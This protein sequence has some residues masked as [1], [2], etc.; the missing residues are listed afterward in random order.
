MKKTIDR[1]LIKT[2]LWVSF[3]IALLCIFFGWLN[4][5]VNY[6]R[7][8]IVFFSA[9]SA[10]NFICFQNSW[11]EKI[12]KKSSF[13]LVTVSLLLVAYF[14][15]KEK[16][17]A[18]LL[19]ILFVGSIVIMYNSNF[20]KIRFRNLPLLKI[21]IISFAWVYTI[22]LIGNTNNSR[23]ISEFLSLY[24]FIFGITIPFDICDM[25]ED[26]IC[27]IPKYLGIRK[28]KFASCLCLF[29]SALSFVLTF[30]N[31]DDLPYVIAWEVAC[32]ISISMIV[33]MEKVHQFFFTRFWI[34]ACSSLPLLIILL[35]KIRVVLF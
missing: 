9:L 11:S 6:N 23:V 15:F 28:S 31:Q 33:F 20:L 26:T 34:E 7:I 18:Q 22:L 19:H 35:Q 2:Q 21:F 12:L 3:M 4:H 14:V 29:S 1:F 13:Y 32:M 10:Y 27:T 8:G 17:L 25:D 30:C 24:L 5:S 16:N